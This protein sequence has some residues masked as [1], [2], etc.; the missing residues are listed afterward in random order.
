MTNSLGLNSD[1]LKQWSD[2]VFP[3]DRQP[4]QTLPMA[5]FRQLS[6]SAW[7]QLASLLVT[8]GIYAHAANSGVGQDQLIAFLQ[9]VLASPARFGLVGV[10]RALCFLMTYPRNQPSNHVPTSSADASTPV[11]GTTTGLATALLTSLLESEQFPPSLL[12]VIAPGVL[13]ML[14]SHGYGSPHLHQTPTPLYHHSH[15]THTQSPRLL[16]PYHHHN[17]RSSISGQSAPP[18]VPPLAGQQ[19]LWAIRA[20][21]VSYSQTSQYLWTHIDPDRLLSRL[22]QVLRQAQFQNPGPLA[23]SLGNITLLTAHNG[24][25]QDMGLFTHLVRF[26][27]PT[28]FVEL[29]MAPVLNPASG[30]SPLSLAELVAC[31]LSIPL[32]DADC[33]RHQAPY[34]AFFDTLLPQWFTTVAQ[35]PGSGSSTHDDST[36]MDEDGHKSGNNNNS[37]HDLGMITTRTLDLQRSA[38]RTVYRFIRW[39]IH[40]LGSVHGADTGDGPGGSDGGSNIL[41]SWNRTSP[42]MGGLVVG[43][44]DHRRRQLFP[45]RLRYLP[46]SGVL[47]V[48]LQHH[49]TCQWV[50]DI[51]KESV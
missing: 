5:Q 43:A 25:A 17:P 22:A 23:A 21:L 41:D 7:L 51:F 38:D 2:L 12:S 49:P 50:Y 8:Q 13:A 31:L 15:H 46:S 20:R 11:G 30:L 14:K 10:L 47:D 45:S 42:N 1:I 18:P 26:L 35:P 24:L 4:L 40:W 32:I 16:H 44:G 19:H 37:R 3:A 36:M 6:P 27:N 48:L 29:V 9:L 34:T 33:P 28:K 39:Y